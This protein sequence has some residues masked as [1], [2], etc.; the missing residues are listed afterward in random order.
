MNKAKYRNQINKVA[1]AVK[2]IIESMKFSITQD[3]GKEKEVQV[4]ER[5]EI[6]D[7]KIEE[8]DGKEI[9]KQWTRS[10][11]EKIELEKEKDFDY[12]EN[13]GFWSLVFWSP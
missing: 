2:D 6:K 9:V 3:Q 5:K 1:L 11:I 8:P 12:Q 7:I 10:G 13:P 4:T